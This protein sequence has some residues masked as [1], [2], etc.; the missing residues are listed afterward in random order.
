MA[1]RRLSKWLSCNAFL[2]ETALAGEA[3]R[4]EA[5]PEEVGGARK[6]VTSVIRSNFGCKCMIRKEVPV[7]SKR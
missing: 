7:T 3:L 1:S 6:K 4:L 5:D 2:G